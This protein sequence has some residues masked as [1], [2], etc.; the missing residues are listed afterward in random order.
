MNTAWLRWRRAYLPRA[1][2]VQAVRTHVVV[3]HVA[4]TLGARP[5]GAPPA[6]RHR[7]GGSFQEAHV[8]ILRSSPNFPARDL[9]FAACSI[10]A[11]TGLSRLQPDVLA[12]VA[13][14]NAG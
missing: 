10:D 14:A 5:T 2:E 11:P 12:G 1:A 13:D 8:T 3:S 6:R 9:V 7:H 4:Q